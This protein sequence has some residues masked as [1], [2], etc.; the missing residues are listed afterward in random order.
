MR[1]LSVIFLLFM[2]CAGRRVYEGSVKSLQRRREPVDIT[3]IKT[4][5]AIIKVYGK[6]PDSERGVVR[7]I[8]V[9]G[10]KYLILESSNQL[11]L[12]KE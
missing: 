7:I 6:V 12:V 9:K 2:A 5:D 10:K 4:E 11:Y 1:T 8:V 3:V